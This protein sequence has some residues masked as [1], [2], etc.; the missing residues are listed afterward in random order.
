MTKKEYRILG[1]FKPISFFMKQ[2]NVIRHA[3]AKQRIKP[4]AYK[5][6]PSGFI[7]LIS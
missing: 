6:E 1:L 2:I 7:S 4:K 5:G 3:E